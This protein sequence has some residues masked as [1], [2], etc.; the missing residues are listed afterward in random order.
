MAG[1][2]MR[3]PVPAS[4]AYRRSGGITRICC[5]PAADGA[6]CRTMIGSS[7]AGVE[8]AFGA[9]QF[10]GLDA[11]FPAPVP[12]SSARAGCR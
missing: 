5:P 2:G 12:M 9:Q 3:L 11:R 1:Q 6:S 8:Q 7:P 10:H 4:K